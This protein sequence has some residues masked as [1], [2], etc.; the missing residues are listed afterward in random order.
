MVNS[1]LAGVFG[2]VLVMVLTL[3]VVPRPLPPLLG[4]LAGS[5]LFAVVWKAQRRR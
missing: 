4:T 3:P 2:G 1:F 5:V